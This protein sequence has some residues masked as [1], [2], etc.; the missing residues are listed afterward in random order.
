MKNFNIQPYDKIEI[1]FSSDD[2]T[3]ENLFY[4]KYDENVKYIHTIDFSPFFSI[5]LHLILH[6]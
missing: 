5:F 3:L 6:L 4:D 2:N 1:H